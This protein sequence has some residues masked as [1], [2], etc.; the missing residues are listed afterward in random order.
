MEVELTHG[1][2]WIVLL[3]AGV[4]AVPMIYRIVRYGGLKGAA[5][6]APVLE[7]IGDVEPSTRGLTKTKLKVHVLD[8]SRPADG[9]H[10]GMEVIYSSFGSWE[11]RGISLTRSE[12]RLLAQELTQAADRSERKAAG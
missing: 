11:M 4:V 1:N 9:P 12:A 5:F 8:P 2:W 7:K 3:I 10:V 6:G